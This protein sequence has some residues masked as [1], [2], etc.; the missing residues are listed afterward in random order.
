VDCDYAY[1]G[2]VSEVLARL[3]DGDTLTLTSTRRRGLRRLAEHHPLGQHR[4][5][6]Y[7]PLWA[8]RSWSLPSTSPA[9]ASQ[10]GVQYV[11]I[12]GVGIEPCAPARPRAS[13]VAPPRSR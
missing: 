12:E 13:P 3:Y 2:E 11:V 7:V 5:R 8:G 10:P 9:S 6:G 1:P 4:G